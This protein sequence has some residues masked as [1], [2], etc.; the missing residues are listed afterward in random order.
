LV[1]HGKQAVVELCQPLIDRFL[2]GSDKMGRD[3][4]FTS[5]ELPL[6]EEPQARRQKCDDC[7][8]FMHFG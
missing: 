5:L 3:A 8:G 1:Q 2:R 6:V 7:G 4:F